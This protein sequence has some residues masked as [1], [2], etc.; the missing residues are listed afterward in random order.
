MNLLDVTVFMISHIYSYWFRLARPWCNPQVVE[1]IAPIQI[2]PTHPG[3]G[4]AGELKRCKIRAPDGQ[5]GWVTLV[6]STDTSGEQ[7]SPGQIEILA[8]G[9]RERLYVC[10]HRIPMA[11]L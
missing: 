11:T 6:A 5:E 4:Q 1:Q 9:K 8:S 2:I 3:A 7:Q 10:R